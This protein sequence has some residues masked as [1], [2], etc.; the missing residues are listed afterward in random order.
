MQ[1][2]VHIKYKLNGYVNKFKCPLPPVSA[3]DKTSR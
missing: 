2:N 3:I 1:P